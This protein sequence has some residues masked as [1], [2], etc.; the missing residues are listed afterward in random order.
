MNALSAA[1][2]PGTSLN[3]RQYVVGVVWYSAEEW[4]RVK[5]IATDPQNFEDSYDQWR[6]IVEAGIHKIPRYGEIRR[7]SVEADALAAW[8]RER[9][10]EVDSQSRVEYV[11]WLVRRA[12]EL[13]AAS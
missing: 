7:V 11:T 1:G 4:S 3:G 12:K 5:A 6:A 8:C 2:T 9:G 10:R 13:A